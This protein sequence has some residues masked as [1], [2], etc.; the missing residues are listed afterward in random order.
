MMMRNKDSGRNVVQF[1]AR[2]GRATTEPARWADAWDGLLRLMEAN[3]RTHIEIG[4][5]DVRRITVLARQAAQC[6]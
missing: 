4:I 3:G 5:D 6:D 2:E 1:N